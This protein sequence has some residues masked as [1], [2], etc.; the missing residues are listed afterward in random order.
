MK[1]YSREHE[2]ARSRIRDLENVKQLAEDNV[3]S[4]EG[5][6]DEVCTTSLF[7]FDLPY[8]DP[9]RQHCQITNEDRRAA[10]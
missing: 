1:H 8:T 3:S 7:L 4:L 9:G 6:F 2:R 10:V 5:L